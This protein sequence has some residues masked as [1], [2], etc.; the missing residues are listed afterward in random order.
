MAFKR[1]AVRS[2]LSPPKIRRFEIG[3]FFIHCESNG[4]SSPSGVYHHALACISSAIVCILFRNDDI[5]NS[6]LMICN[7]F[8]IDISVSALP[9]IFNKLNTQTTECLGTQT[10]AEVLFLCGSFAKVGVSF[11]SL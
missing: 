9:T 11:G 7:F 3:G 5:Q 4:I 8:E 6:V 2:R 10:R 1:S